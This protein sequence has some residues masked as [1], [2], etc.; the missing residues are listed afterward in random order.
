MAS[1]DIVAPYAEDT[2]GDLLAAFATELGIPPADLPGAA[3]QFVLRAQADWATDE[4]PGTSV[5]EVAAALAEFWRY[6][7]AHA[8]E[9]QPALRMRRAACARPGAPPYDVL[10]IAQRDRPFLVDSVMAAIAEGG[11]SVRAMFHP[12]VG[13]GAAARSMIQV[14]LDPV[15]EDRE[16]ALVESIAS[17]LADVCLAVDDFAAMRTLLLRTIDELAA[18]PLQ[19]SPEA[20]AEYLT[21]LNWLEGDRFVFLGARVYDY[22]RTADGGYAAEEPD[23][24]P[25]DGLGVLRD[26]ERVVLRRSNEPAVLSDQVRRLLTTG[27]PVVVAKS[28]LRSRVHRRVHAD[29]I[30]VRRY[31]A[32][33]RPAG[34]VRLVGLF[35]A[36]AYETPAREVPLIRAKLTQVMARAGHAPDSH[37]AK[38]LRNILETWPRDELFQTGVDELLHMAG[39]VLHLFDRPRVRLFARLD[40]FD[41]FI[42]VLLYVPRERYDTDLRARA[43]EILARAYGGRIAAY[44]PSFSDAPL[45]RVHYIVGVRQGR[46]LDPDMAALEALIAEAARTWGDR[47]EVAVR[48]A[49]PPSAVAEKLARYIDAF[50]P[51]YRDHYDAAEALADIEVIEPMGAQEPV[52]VRAFRRANDPSTTFRFKLYRPGAAAPLADVLPVLDHMGLKALIEEGHLLAPHGTNGAPA[53][54]WVHEFMLQD[55][56]GGHLSFAAVKQPFEA[57]FVAIW[58]G[59]AESDGFN[60]LVLELGFRGARRRCCVP[61]RATGNKPGSIRASRCKRKHWPIT[62]RSRA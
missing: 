24:N 43:G 36:E 62:R 38:R 19:I 30:G 26:R 5:A 51:G 12:V 47:F 37:N 9:A 61:S 14:Y 41:R 28:N 35:T 18:A 55:D 53:T 49:T 23:Y 2:A 52:R 13:T 33:G 17:S 20:R 42:S 54:V 46:R 11:F 25:Q 7:E 1:A 59:R 6:G 32:D 44:Y 40:P 10:E 56:R 22:P 58:S 27:E 60:R 21:F 31:G 4:L 34:E 39:G 8:G 45:A 50:P 48:A 15:G 3:C 57:A 29:Y 16:V